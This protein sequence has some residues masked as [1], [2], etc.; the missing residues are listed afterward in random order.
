MKKTNVLIYLQYIPI[1]EQAVRIDFFIGE[2][3]IFVR[4]ACK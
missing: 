2:E 3:L 4:G 1:S